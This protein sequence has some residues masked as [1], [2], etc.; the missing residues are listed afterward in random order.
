MREKFTVGILGAPFG[1]KG[2]I[3]VRSLSGEYDH[4][5]ALK[6]VIIHKE[7]SGQAEEGATEKTF[8]IEETLRHSGVLFLKFKGI[9]SPEAVKTLSGAELVVSRDMAAPLNPGEYYVEDLKGMQVV[10][11]EGEILGEITGIIEG[12]GGELAEIRLPGGERRLIPFRKEFFGDISL[13]KR[14]VVL[15]ERW[16][17]E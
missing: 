5:A 4:I 17:L 9:D 12:G 2:L 13:E 11:V 6:S 16:I 8:E 10:T 1:V 15:L 3:K 14:N 7:S